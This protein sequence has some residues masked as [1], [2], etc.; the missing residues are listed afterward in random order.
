MQNYMAR[1]RIYN[2]VSKL[3]LCE[4]LPPF[5]KGGGPRVSV[6]GSFL[7]LIL[8]FVRTMVVNILKSEYDTIK[9]LCG[10][11]LSNR[12]VDRQ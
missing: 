11:P 2:T 9:W 4:A 12:E 10:L 7:A 6:V 5:P 8:Q 3:K 1:V